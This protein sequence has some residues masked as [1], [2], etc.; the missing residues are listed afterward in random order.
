MTQIYTKMTHPTLTT[1]MR[2]LAQTDRDLQIAIAQEIG[3]AVIT[4]YQWAKYYP[5]RLSKNRA[6]LKVILHYMKKAHK[7]NKSANHKK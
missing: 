6:A 5:E 3:I 4:I 2:I 1:E 7:K